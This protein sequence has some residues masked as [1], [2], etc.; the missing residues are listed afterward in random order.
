MRGSGLAGTSADSPRTTSAVSNSSGSS[1]FGAASASSSGTQLDLRPAQRDHLPEVALGRPR[2]S[3]RRRSACRARGRRRAACRRAGRGRGSS[4]ASRSRCAP[5][6]RARARPRCRRGA[7]GRTRPCR[8][9]SGSRRRRPSAS[10]PRRRRR[11]RTSRRWRVAAAQVLADLL[12]VERALGDEDHVGAAGHAGVGG[13][14]AGVAAHHLDDDH[15]VVRLGGRVQAVDRVGGDLHGG[16]EAEREVGAGEVV[17]DRLRDAD[18][19]DAR[20][21]PAAGRRRACPRRRSGSARRA[22]ARAS[23][24]ADALEPALLLVRVRARRAE[25]RAAAVQDARAWSRR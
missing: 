9:C 14:P 22:A 20:P 19:V 25:D 23:D 18:D 17:V 8:S 4:C 16:L 13:D 10:R 1:S 12:D 5:R 21:R 6:S 2:R 15:A 7:R 24:G 3:P 11:S